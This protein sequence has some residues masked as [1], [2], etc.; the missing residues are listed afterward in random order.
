MSK[1]DITE[2]VKEFKT[3]KNMSLLKGLTDEELHIFIDELAGSLGTNIG[4]AAI[5]TDLKKYI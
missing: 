3:T 1:R 2:L 4:K 5:Y